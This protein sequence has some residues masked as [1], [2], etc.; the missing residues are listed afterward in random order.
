[1]IR[2]NVKSLCATLMFAASLGAT[3][4]LA[5][6]LDAKTVVIKHKEGDQYRA[7][8]LGR[9]EIL[10]ESNRAV[11]HFND[12]KNFPDY[13]HVMIWTDRTTGETIANLWLSGNSVTVI[14]IIREFKS[15]PGIPH[16]AMTLKSFIP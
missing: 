3:L 6:P 15:E 2:R 13:R 11:L 16:T 10:A 14:A 7:R 8:R 5:A 9:V 1:M 12:E 4:I